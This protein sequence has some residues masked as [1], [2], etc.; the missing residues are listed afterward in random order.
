MRIK[1]SIRGFPQRL[2]YKN[3]IGK[4]KRCYVLTGEQ[5]I[6]YKHKKYGPARQPSLFELKE[7]T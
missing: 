1:S 5:R 2:S 6:L 7:Q 3:M 4:K